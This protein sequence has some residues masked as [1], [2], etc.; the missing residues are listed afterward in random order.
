MLFPRLA[1]GASRS[2]GSCHARFDHRYL[3]GLRRSLLLRH[4]H[5]ELI[6]SKKNAN[7][8]DKHLISEPMSEPSTGPS[9]QSL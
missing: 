7:H 8:F 4:A 5:I 1:S 2:W 3:D 6:S 9:I